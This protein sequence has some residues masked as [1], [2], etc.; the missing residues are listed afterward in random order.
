MPNTV[1]WEFYG[2]E[3]AVFENGMWVVQPRPAAIPSLSLRT[4][5]DAALSLFLDQGK[6][7]MQLAMP[8]DSVLH[9]TIARCK[10]AHNG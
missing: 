6:K 7:S 8:A 10:D 2:Y 3:D 4:S 5:S 9:L 1:W